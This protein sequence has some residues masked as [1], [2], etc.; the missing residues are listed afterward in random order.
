MYYDLDVFLSLGRKELK[1]NPTNSSYG[2]PLALS[3]ELYLYVA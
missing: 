3:G 2:V 1:F